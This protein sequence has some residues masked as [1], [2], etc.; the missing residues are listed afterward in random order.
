M[1]TSFF[2]DIAPI[3]FEGPD[4]SNPLAY[5]WY[6]P[7][8]M[9]LGK[10]MEDHLRFA[11][12]Y[13]HSFC[14]TGGD[15]FGSA[16]L[17]RPWQS[18]D[19]MEGARLKADVAFEAFRLLGIPFFTFHDRDIA[20]EG[21]N[22][23]ESL[24]NFRTIA[25]VLARKIEETKVRLLW[26]T[27]NLFSHPRFMAGAATNPDPEVFAYAAATVKNCL[28]VTQQLGGQNYVLWGGREGYE[29][30][31]NTDLKHEM[32]QLGRFLSL[33]VDYKHKIGFTGTILIEP[34]PKE[35]TKHQYD[36][37]TATVYGFLKR[38]G[39]ENEVKV[40]IEANHAMLAGH[41]FEHEIA[42]A[43]A[44][45]IFGS[46]DTNR[47]DSLLGWDTDQF[48][49]NVQDVALSLYYVLQG[50]GFSTGGLNFDAKIRRQSIAPDDLLHA[51][52]GGIDTCAHA[53]L[54]AAQ[55]VES[56]KLAGHVAQRYA[57]WRTPEGQT[58]LKGPL[59]LADIAADVE[60]RNTEPVP[61]SGRQEYLENLVN[62]YL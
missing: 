55:M 50:G 58:L 53:L 38:Y 59:S 26:G 44:L 30:L 3:R 42:L 12:C 24:R 7:D 37:D 39:L 13:W 27:A 49:N 52:I 41:T 35:P 18:G 20:P 32:D 47:G 19:A 8:R 33:V 57:K 23:A 14:L 51:H 40:N 45:G 4:S 31:L 6:Q 10:R 25:D 16:T 11:V 28:D 5:K 46:L 61:Q 22:F 34:K 2:G 48:P 36:F 21:A 62:S 29:T 1:S 43:N 15:P 56:G 54:I 9:I 60:R 17:N